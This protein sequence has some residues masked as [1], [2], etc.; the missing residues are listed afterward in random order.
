MTRGLSKP[1]TLPVFAFKIG[2]RTTCVS[3]LKTQLGSKEMHFRC[4]SVQ[5]FSWQCINTIMWWR[6][7]CK[8]CRFSPLRIIF[9]G[10]WLSDYYTIFHFGIFRL[11][12]IFIIRFL[13]LHRMFI[14]ATTKVATETKTA[15]TKITSSAAIIP[16]NI[17]SP[18]HH[19]LD[20]M[21]YVS[22]F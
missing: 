18:L 14:T 19:P 7:H 16:Q 9:I 2:H 17:K 8:C 3:K 13:F 10:A 6:W 1:F 11:F 12:Y 22:T 15:A 20:N 4:F 5:T 21:K